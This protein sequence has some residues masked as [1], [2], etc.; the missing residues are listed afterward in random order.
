MNARRR[1]G[2]L[3]PLFSLAS[4]RSWGVGEFL[5]LPVFAQWL[6]SANQAF[7]QILP[8]TE[9][10]EAD[11]SPYSA[12][13]A[14]ALD[15]IYISVPAMEDFHA[16][17][18]ERRFTADD[19]AALTRIQATTRVDHR[20]VRALKSRWL[21]R[22]YEHFM[23]NEVPAGTA[24]AHAFVTFMRDEAWWLDDYA[25]F[26]SIRARQ[27]L[28]PWWEWPEPLARR[29]DDA[30][31]QAR[32]QLRGEIYLR[33]YVQWIAAQQWN[34]A[35]ERSRP[36][37]VFG[38]VPFMISADSPDVWTRQNEFR[39]DS[40]VGVPPDAFS[41]TGQDWGLPPWRW[42]V[43]AQNDFEWMKRRA[44]RTAT[45][46]DGFRLDHLVGL[47]RTYMRP[48]EKTT[49]PFFAPDEE[50]QQQQL[51]E[52]LIGLYQDTGAEIIAEDLGTVP[53]FVRASLHRMSVP[54]FK[55]MRWEKHWH[56]Y[57][58]PYVDPAEYPETSV[59]T[60]GTHDTEPMAIWW[61]NL[62]VDERR[63]VLQ[64]PSLR[65]DLDEGLLQQFE[66]SSALDRA[67]N[68]AL[69]RALLDAQSRLVITPLQDLFGWRDRIN[70]PAQVT[71]QNWT[72]RM[73]WPVDELANNP[74]A[75]SRA[76]ALAR[77]TEK[78]GRQVGR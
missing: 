68:D 55:V 75:T 13:T 52:R 40:T 49:P 56:S 74:E 66:N 31:T 14:M 61:E 2:I 23:A 46:F 24:R 26:L 3:A 19:R 73:P 12:L 62:S 34:D 4:T 67:L 7:V 30:M 28:R 45:L 59:A 5:D 15:P 53:D 51:G 63:Q 22:A 32:E 6:Q 43:M 71:D 57:G 27:A 16:A 64:I 76:D 47:Y 48:I 50:W 25:V 78:A 8:I 44:R 29:H 42:D 33:K 60:T 54:G 9:I 58:Q 17:G 21:R 72:W 65:R 1:S 10:P 37:Q 38:D 35:R 11:T 20:A 70:T 69:L 39:F 18:G 36:L 41:D 77:W